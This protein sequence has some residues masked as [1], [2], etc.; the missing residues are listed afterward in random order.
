[1]FAA[2]LIV[3]GNPYAPVDSFIGLQYAALRS[4]DALTRLG[5]PDVRRI[6]GMYSVRQWWR[7]A[8]GVE[9]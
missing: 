9:P 6:S 7:W 4:V 2:G 5:V 1:V 3:S 8:R